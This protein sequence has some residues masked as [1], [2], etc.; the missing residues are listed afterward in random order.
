MEVAA[1]LANTPTPAI[2]SQGAQ[3]Q[4]SQGDGQKAPF[5]PAVLKDQK[6]ALSAANEMAQAAS[7]EPIA[8]AKSAA[9][10][11][12]AVSSQ[13]SPSARQNAEWSR[14]DGAPNW[15]TLSA[16]SKGYTFTDRA[17][18][19]YQHISAMRVA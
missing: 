15:S 3:A 8:H 2:A 11:D 16:Q 6:A 4:T 10:S 17:I 12:T 13:T 5:D 9:T 1:R 14:T 19:L 18:N 7:D